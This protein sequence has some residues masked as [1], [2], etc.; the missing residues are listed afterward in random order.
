MIM[1]SLGDLANGFDK[2]VVPRIAEFREKAT[3]ALILEGTAG[4]SLEDSLHLL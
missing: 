2:D 4:A 3:T 1:S